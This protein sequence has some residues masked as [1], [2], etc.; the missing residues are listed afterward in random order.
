MVP[1]YGRMTGGFY[2]KTKERHG[3]IQTP[4]KIQLPGVR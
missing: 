1:G 4:G 2:A 3:D